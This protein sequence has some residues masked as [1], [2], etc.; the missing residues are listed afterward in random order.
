[1]PPAVLTPTE[2]KAVDAALEPV[3][4]V[5][6]SK[7]LTW[8]QTHQSLI[9]ILRSTLTEPSLSDQLAAIRAPVSPD[10]LVSD[11]IR[12]L[13]P[14]YAMLI[15]AIMQF[16]PLPNFID[17]RAHLLAFEAQQSLTALM[18]L[19]QRRKHFTLLNP[20][21]TVPATH[22]ALFPVSSLQSLLWWVHSCLFSRLQSI[23][24]STIPSL[25]TQL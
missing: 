23:P 8:Y 25:P 11:V 15:T 12:G 6:N 21:L 5:P 16:P 24:S 13:G 22:V 7:Y 19:S 4:P 18:L 17:L 9:S 1:M 10:D 14:D 3:V 2:D 20:S